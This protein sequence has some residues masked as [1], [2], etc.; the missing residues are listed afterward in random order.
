M[1]SGTPMRH[2]VDETFEVYVEILT[3]QRT[4][5]Y[6]NVFLFI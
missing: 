5:R 3:L 6:K 4:Y 1:R 2:C